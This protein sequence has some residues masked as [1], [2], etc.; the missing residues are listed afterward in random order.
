MNNQIR[1][2]VITGMGAITPNANSVAEFKKALESGKSGIASIE[3]L[4]ELKFS[5]QVGGI[6][7]N[8]EAR[9]ASFFDEDELRSMSVSMQYGCVAALEAYKDAGLEV[10][11]FDSQEVQKNTGAIIGTG[12]A[13]ME[14]IGE[15]LVPLVD[16]GK[17][18]RLGSSMVEN[19]MASSVSAKV[20]GLL[21]L[22]NQ[23]TTNSSACSTGTEAIISG[24]HRIKNGYADRMIVGGVE[25]HSP[26]A[27]A[28]FDA[29]RVLS[30]KFND[31]PESASRPMS[32]TA[33][34]FVPG[35]GA[36]IL[37]IEEYE[38]AK[39]RGAKIYAEI[40]GGS[41]N[42]GG[43]RQGGSMTAPNKSSVKE[44]IRTA[45]IEADIQPQEIEYIN[46]HLTAT[47][48]DT[49]EVQNWADAL[50]L[51]PEKLPYI[52]STKS[53]IGHALGA[54]GAIESIATVLQLSEG[55]LHPSLNCE[56][57]HEKI[58]PFEKSIV[59]K[60]FYKETNIAAKA[61]FGF[62]DVNSCLIIKKGD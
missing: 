41:V 8:P 2:V 10:P 16:E 62:G 46:G 22:G 24:F 38:T 34:G 43:Q 35:S 32:Q 45:L 33:C 28:G 18:R 31:T 25:G 5:C 57:L 36:G 52:N 56:D 47:M 12:I 55:F 6:P 59:R 54:S 58:L 13:G 4:K 15:K 53:M 30:K 61:S 17:T 26:Y 3:R 19:I 1:R 27:W 40:L 39:K 44:C 51:A 60:V 29:M 50:E 48:A 21:A 11:A 49:L 14:T 37:V 7:K 9:I 42:C 20:G 23:V